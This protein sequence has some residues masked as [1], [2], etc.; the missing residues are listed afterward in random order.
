MIKEEFME[1]E[2]IIQEMSI[3]YQHDNRPWMIGYS[4]GKDSTL[5]CCLVMEMLKRLPAKARTKT[6]YIVSSDTMVENP[7]VKNY[8]HKMSDMINEAG[9]D[10]NIKADIIYPNIDDTFWVKVIGLG[11]PTP[12]APGFRW[13]TERLKIKPMNEYTLNKI[14]SNG[15]VVLLLGVRKAESQYRANNIRN[16]EIEGKLLVPHSDIANA[17]VYNPLTEIPNEI[18]W[19]YLLKDDAKT[20]WGSDNKYLFSLYQ[21]ENLGEEQSVIGEIDKDKIKVTG[22]SRFGCWICTMVKE[23]KSLKAFIDKGETWLEPLRDYRNW[24]L[25][26]RNTPSARE[27]KRRNGSVYRKADGELGQGPFTLKARQ[28]MLKK[29]LEL[30]VSSGLELISLEELKR[31]DSMWDAEGDLTRRCLVDMYYAIKGERLPWDSFKT[32][33]FA[34]DVIDEI[35]KQCAEN[36]V[37]FELISKLIIEIEANKNY[38]R[39]SMVT[40]AFDRVLNQGW[41][42]F[43]SIEKGL[44]YEN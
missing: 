5:L 4:G 20:P 30:E 1:F 27:Y 11:Y 9:K 32:A 14:K 16:R 7:I 22:N 37:E 19:K 10:L 23:D 38:T 6:V 17:Y 2:N 24:L 39:S 31:I 8:M 3:V 12:E 18:V 28:E 29:L 42:H 41:L 34:P 44:N 33:V 36:D 35:K 40:K 21:G 26:M 25:E 43:D 15:E 13:C